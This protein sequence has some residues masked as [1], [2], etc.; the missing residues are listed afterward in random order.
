M[1]PGVL[2]QYFHWYIPAD[3]S[4]YKEAAG[5]AGK[6]ADIGIT[7]VWLPPA[8]K[9]E[10]GDHASGYDIYDLFDLGEF[11]QKNSIRTKFG[12]K[13]EFQQAVKILHDHKIHVYADIVLNHKAGADETERIRVRKVNPDNRNEFISEP[14]D[15][16]AYTK[17]TFPGRN[18]KYSEF[19]WDYRC[20][21]GVDYD[22]DTKE[23][24]IFSILNDYGAGWEGV[25]D[26]EKGNYD[27]LMYA[28][29]EFRNPAVRSE[30]N[31]WG[32]W[33]LDQIPF[34]GVRLDAVK[35]MSPRFYNEWL[36]QMRAIKPDLFAV[37]EYWAPGELS[38]LLKYID[39]T[40][41][42]MSLFDAPLHHNFY[43]ASKQGKEFNLTKIFE[44]SLLGVH[45]DLAVTVVDNHDTQPLQSLEAPVE[46]WFKPLAYAL[47]LLREAGYPCIFYPDLYGAHYTGKGHDGN[48]QEI[49]LDKCENLDK[50]LQARKY[51]ACGPQQDYL[52]HANCIGWIR[53]GIAEI[54]RSGCAILMSNGEEG[55]KRMKMGS[56]HAGKT[57]IDFLGKY[58]GE[59]VLDEEGCAEFHVPAGTVSIWISK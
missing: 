49:F 54:P 4:L 5:N 51:F 18:K 23:T 25:V 35:H 29:I 55:F 10:G 13:E 21:T 16:T 20:F 33:Y 30:L 28:D 26:N 34:D 41:S 24:A 14:F 1:A 2:M 44:N 48:D 12:T 39:A 59:I 50:L 6:L 36:D 27:Y 52:D 38:L 45:P 53:E 47:I 37:G 32:K 42:R 19:I 15:I 11:D 46:I 31:Y 8:C 7:A 58:P 56:H 3:G 9:G 57:F 40:E 43:Q 17:F 22:H